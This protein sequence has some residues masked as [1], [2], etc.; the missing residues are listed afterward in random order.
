MN[1]Q[2][3]KGVTNASYFDQASRNVACIAEVLNKSNIDID[4]I[5]SLGFYVI[6][7]EEKL[8][9]KTNLTKYTDEDN[10]DNKVKRRVNEYE[11]E[12]G[13]RKGEWYNKWFLPTKNKA[14]I[15]CLS[16]EEVIRFIKKN[17]KN[18]GKDL[19]VFYKKCLKYND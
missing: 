14:K 3:S 18:Y 11:G 4:Q 10:V 12:S 19:N 16:W 8:N 13:K 9:E 1:S 7:P 6:A 17:D 15:E 5:D 2:L